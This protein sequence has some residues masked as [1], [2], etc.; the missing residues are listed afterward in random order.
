MKRFFD[1]ISSLYSLAILVIPFIIIAFLVKVSSSGPIIYR[2]Y[3]VGRYGKIFNLYKFRTMVKNADELG[4]PSAG[5]DDSRIT[6]I[7]S[8]LRR[9]KIDELPQLINVINGD[10]SLVGP[11]PEVLSEVNK[12]NNDQLKVLELRPGL[13]DYASLWNIDEGTVLAGASNP[14][15]AYRK[16]IQP[17]KLALQLKYLKEKSFWLD[18]KIIAY[19]IIKLVNKRWIP[20]ELQEY[21]PPSC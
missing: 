13:T 8:F 10:M 21:P 11:R 19:T 5:K 18:I 4:G 14:H 16:Y 17:T 9:L 1:L 3:R 6:K 2:S 12:Y 15:L 7:G 20:H